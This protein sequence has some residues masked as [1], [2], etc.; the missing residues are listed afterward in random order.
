MVDRVDVVPGNDLRELPIT[1]AY[2]I[3]ATGAGG[4]VSAEVPVGG[5]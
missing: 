3:R 1:I 4:T 2:R 5:A